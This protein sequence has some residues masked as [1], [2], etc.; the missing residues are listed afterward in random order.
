MLGQRGL[1]APFPRPQRRRSLRWPHG[2]PDESGKHRRAQP[3][4]ATVLCPWQTLAVHGWAMRLLALVVALVI[5]TTSAAHV[6]ERVA[7]VIGN[8]APAHKNATTLQNPRNDATDVAEA[9]R[10]LGFGTIVGLDLD[11]GYGREVDQLCPCVQH[12][13]DI[14]RESMG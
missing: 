14:S 2:L 1:L 5:L 10:G 8:A 3:T 6:E 13:L 9:L 12:H 11:S 7:P 4:I